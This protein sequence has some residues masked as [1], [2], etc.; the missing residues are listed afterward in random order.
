[1]SPPSPTASPSDPKSDLILERL[2]GLHPKLIDLTLD[3]CELLLAKLDH[4]EKKLPPVI[5]VAGTNGKGSVCAFL[6]AMMEAA[7]LTVHRYSSPHLVRFHE[8]I[9]LQ[10]KPIEEE[11][12][13]QLLEECE[14]VNGGENITYFEI[15][16]VAALLA[17]S[18]IQAD[19]VILEVG[20]GGRFDATN[21]IERPAVSVIT[22]IGFDHQAF[23]GDTIHEIAGEKAGIIKRDVP[24][25]IAPQVHDEALARFEKEAAIQHASL[26][27]GGQDWT[28]FEE[29]GRLVYQDTDGLL[30]LPL[31]SL[32]G[33]HQIENAGVAIAALR[34]WGGAEISDDAIAHG[35]AQT[36]WPARMQKLKSG[37]LVDIAGDD[38]ELWL[39]G[40]HNPAGG[41]AAAAVLAD[42]DERNT[43][44]LY[45]I[46]AMLNT[47]DAVGFFENFRDLARQVYTFTAPGTQA[48][49]PA[50]A[51]AEFAI[52]AGLDAYPM[53][54]LGAAV[55]RAIGH[56][57]GEMGERPR[58]LLCGTLYLAGH[59]LA[60]HT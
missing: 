6:Q 55:G 44:P 19:V 14:T 21:V 26:V 23:L 28:A 36:V 45:L 11:A 29:H 41:R 49:V 54:D 46:T 56:A 48:A 20:L 32:I 27:I 30:D 25:I 47:K 40:C 16:T 3:R 31:P 60:S 5:H 53:H 43:R 37:S 50:E 38:V 15:T 22:Q 7:G 35:L 9:V 59:I 52:E 34:H 10:G 42:L 1:M 24:A 51:L 33:A 8:R 39:D 2:M 4:P 13:A 57:E 18:R 12:L 17:F 58:I